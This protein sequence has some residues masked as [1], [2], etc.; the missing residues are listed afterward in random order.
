[1]RQKQTTFDKAL[2]F[3]SASIEEVKEITKPQKK[4]LQWLFEKWVML[5]VVITS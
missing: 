2:G 3:I 1:V 4:F 5:R